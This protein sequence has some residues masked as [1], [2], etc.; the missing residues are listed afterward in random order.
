MIE[1]SFTGHRACYRELMEELAEGTVAHEVEWRIHFDDDPF[2]ESATHSTNCLV[3]D[4]MTDAE[5]EARAWGRE[6]KSSKKNG[7]SS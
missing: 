5:R 7:S 4:A 3:A 2:G 1:F 6:A